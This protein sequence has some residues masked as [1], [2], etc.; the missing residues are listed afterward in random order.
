MVIATLLVS[1]VMVGAFSLE[2]VIV[3]QRNNIALWALDA[4]PFIFALWGQIANFKDSATIKAKDETNETDP[5][6][7]KIFLNE[8]DQRL[9]ALRAALADA[10]AKGVARQ[11]HTLK[12]ISRHFLRERADPTDTAGLP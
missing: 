9:K 5:Q 7:I 3:A 8:S 6:L 10:D 12:S 1:Y 4:M 11:S 2:G